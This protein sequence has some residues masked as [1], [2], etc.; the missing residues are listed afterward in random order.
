MEALESLLFK[1]LHVLI[2]F[3]FLLDVILNFV[4]FLA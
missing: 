4:F 3:L 2:F 1:S